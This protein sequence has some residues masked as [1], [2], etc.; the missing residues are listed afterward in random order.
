MPQEIYFQRPD[1]WTDEEWD[2]FAHSLY[3]FVE[4]FLLETGLEV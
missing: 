3:K 4:N 1:D 2:D